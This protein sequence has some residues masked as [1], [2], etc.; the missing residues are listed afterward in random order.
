MLIIDV[1]DGENIDRALKRYKRKFIST[2]T[3]R[4]LRKRR[5]FTKPSVTRRHELLKAA[6]KQKKYG[7]EG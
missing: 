1:K 5:E 6:Y 4:Q 2:G 7:N 3:I